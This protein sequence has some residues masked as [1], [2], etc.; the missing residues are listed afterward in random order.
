MKPVKAQG[1]PVKPSMGAGAAFGAVGNACLDHFEANRAGMLAGADPEFLHQGRVALRRLR[2]AFRVFGPFAKGRRAARAYE[3][4][5]R[6]LDKL[7]PARDWDVFLAFTV[8]PAVVEAP[9][10]R[11]LAALARAC[12]RERHRA[13]DA[14]RHAVGSRRAR[15]LVR[16]VREFLADVPA[17]P[18]LRKF[19]RERLARC[20]K[21]MRRRA[22]HLARLD[23][24]RLHRLRLAVKR[25]RYATH[26]FAPLFPARRVESL[27][28]ALGEIQDALGGAN[29]CAVALGLLKR[30]RGK[31]KALLA[32][33]TEKKLA[34]HHRELRSAWK[35]V[36]AADRFWE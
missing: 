16:K 18:P 29:D 8:A 25:L 12:E 7:G 23:A 14:A 9:A 34:G 19:A 17:G 36:Q 4:L 30:L 28:D 6:L 15:S 2:S 32:G 26:F 21:R 24:E 33:H 31:G 13:R 22:R 5:E 3:G 11:G 35:A 1:S 10:H 20:D 27:P